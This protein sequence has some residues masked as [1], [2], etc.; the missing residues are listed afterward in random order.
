M[1]NLE[2]IPVKVIEEI[3]RRWPDVN[4]SE[5]GKPV[6]IGIDTI[7]HRLEYM[8]L[9]GNPERRLYTDCE[10]FETTVVYGW[11]TQIYSVRFVGNYV[12]YIWPT[13]VS[14]VCTQDIKDEK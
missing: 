13:D 4:F 12:Y 8:S 11:H 10:T 1:S 9:R 2:S 5:F 14:I 7:T 3:Y 6:P